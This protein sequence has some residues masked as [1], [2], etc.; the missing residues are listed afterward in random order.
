MSISSSSSAPAWIE[1]LRR[2][3]G[4]GG[5][6]DVGKRRALRFDG[7]GR[8]PARPRAAGTRRFS[9]KPRRCCGDPLVEVIDQRA[10]GVS[11]LAQAD[12]FAAAQAEVRQMV[13]E[14]ADVVGRAEAHRLE[15]R[16]GGGPDLL[17]P[18]AR[19]PGAAAPPC[20]TRRWR[21]SRGVDRLERF[22]QLAGFLF[23]EPEIA[24][25]HL[26]A[27]AHEFQID[28]GVGVALA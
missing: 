18:R 1:P 3:V 10:I 4:L 13:D 12:D 9:P 11:Q 25:E 6:G 19:S 24:V 17:G 20:R 7:R 27:A 15:K 8:D 2:G 23:L 21:H 22:R 28:I 16:L 14:P 5:L 26:A